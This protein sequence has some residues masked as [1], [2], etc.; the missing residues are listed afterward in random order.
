LLKAAAST[1]NLINHLL[2]AHSMSGP[3]VK[4]AA[5]P[6][7]S[8]SA[9]A[10]AKPSA[11]TG[12][13][14]QSTL[15]AFGVTRDVVPQEAGK[16][17]L[18]NFMISTRQ[19][20]HM[21]DNPMWGDFADLYKVPS[22]SPK[23]MKTFLLQ[24]TAQL[25]ADF[26]ALRTKCPGISVAV[27]E[28]S[29]RMLLP[30]MG[31]VVTTVDLDFN[32][33]EH[34]PGMLCLDD[35]A[36]SENL[37]KWLQEQLARLGILTNDLASVCN[38]NAANI[39]KAMTLDPDL[40]DAQQFCI[41]HLLNIAVQKAMLQPLSVQ[42]R[43]IVL[44]A[45]MVPLDA[46]G[47]DEGGSFSTADPADIEE[48]A[49]EPQLVAGKRRKT[50]NTKFRDYIT[51]LEA[52]GD[53]LNV[54]DEE[55]DISGD[56]LDLLGRFMPEA[57]TQ[58]QTHQITWLMERVRDIVKYIRNH[59]S[60]KQAFAAAQGK[61]NQKAADEHSKA[62]GTFH[63][64][65]AQYEAQCT[66][67][68]EQQRLIEAGEFHT[69]P[70]CDDDD[71]DVILE[72]PERPVCPDKPGQLRALVMDIVTR[73]NSQLACICSVIE[74]HEALQMMWDNNEGDQVRL[75]YE[76]EWI[77]LEA[78]ADYL[79]HFEQL[80]NQ[81]QGAKVLASESILVVRR[82]QELLTVNG[83]DDAAVVV[84]LKTTILA[85]LNNHRAKLARILKH[86]ERNSL[87]ALCACVDPRACNLD[88]FV[89]PEQ[90]QLPEAKKIKEEIRGHLLVY[91]FQAV[92]QWQA[93]LKRYKEEAA[94]SATARPQKKQKT[95]ASMRPGAA[96]AAAAATATTT[97]KGAA[98]A[99]AT[100]AT[101][102]PKGAAAAAATAATATTTTTTTTTTL[103]G[104]AAAAA[105]T[106]PR[107]PSTGLNFAAFVQ[108]DIEDDSADLE[109]AAN[110]DKLKDAIAKELTLFLARAREWFRTTFVDGG[111]NQRSTREQTA[112]V[113]A[114][115]RAIA[116]DFPNLRIA[117]AKLFSVRV[118]SA[119][120]ERLFF[121]CWPA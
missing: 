105:N 111:L 83:D 66:A 20:F 68:D 82:F 4:A 95:A 103:K 81:V 22:C 9:T 47:N 84:A 59:H 12:A 42:E 11:A 6:A 96:S 63:V 67:Y 104:A 27:D 46:Y 94:V 112:A 101:A 48:G 80:T 19:P 39:S 43:E 86:L 58:M 118:T 85:H 31:I 13:P 92:K 72:Q 65:M 37:L 23:T 100:A 117:A 119:S 61:V 87:A 69:G 64:R 57:P 51:G 89:A 113:L 71:D 34:S 52:T 121:I 38:D 15:G 7:A 60:A 56:D 25:R 97:P 24:C 79:I 32:M 73:W 99:A 18:L 54:G 10:S 41:A 1:S 21:L 5:T 93:R 28:W 115:W 70:I 55:I 2:N 62:M 45:A 30:W 116:N 110:D 50:P 8:G 74:N 91:T 98:A 109:V 16:R 53:Y 90:R 44:D 40:Q 76:D 49:F 17:A 35:S 114:W 3:S 120:A 36:T 26:F 88:F 107:A 78:I 102:T 75:F 33:L 29:D 14:Q 77:D 106:P 108:H